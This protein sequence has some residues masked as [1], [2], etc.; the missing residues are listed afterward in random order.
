[1]N[2]IIVNYAVYLV[3]KN[4]FKT[5]IKNITVYETIIFVN[6]YRYLLFRQDF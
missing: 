1:M 4:N 2:I 3:E 6:S 5:K